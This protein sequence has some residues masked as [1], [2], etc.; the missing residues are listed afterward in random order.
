MYRCL[1]LVCLSFFGV[2]SLRA[3]LS[4][5]VEVFL[6]G[7]YQFDYQ[8][9]ETGPSGFPGYDLIA[10]YILSDTT[11]YTLNSATL[12]FDLLNPSFSIEMDGDTVFGSYES[13][14]FSS[15]ADLNSFT[16]FGNYTANFNFGSDGSISSTY[17]SLVEDTFPNQPYF[18]GLTPSDFGIANYLYIDPTTP[19]LLTWPAFENMLANDFIVLE[20]DLY[21][22]DGTNPY[23]VLFGDTDFL[24]SELQIIADDVVTDSMTS[25]TL[26][27]GVLDPNT[28]YQASIIFANVVEENTT[29]F[30]GIGLSLLA[31]ETEVAVLTVPEPATVAAIIS[32][33]VFAGVVYR[34]RRKA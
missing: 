26:P 10:D 20:F 24:P 16:D 7:Q 31:S 29:D 15:R 12:S 18:T 25:Y 32:G 27:A 33:I 30:S 1:L 5:N 22:S 6:L 9:D 4:D 2:P 3:L 23:T 28:M 19:T 21:N 34:R 14:V 17:G 8:N 11:P 13:P